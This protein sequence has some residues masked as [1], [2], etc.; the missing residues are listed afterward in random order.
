MDTD[1]FQV[2]VFLCFDIVDEYEDDY[3]TRVL[4][5]RSS[6]LSSDHGHDNFIT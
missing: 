1:T 3:G 2:K 6:A 4:S 5:F